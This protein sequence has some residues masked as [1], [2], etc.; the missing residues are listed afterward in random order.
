G[1]NCCFVAG[2]TLLTDILQPQEKSRI[3]GLVD[4]LINVASATGGFGGG[5]VFWAIGFTITSQIGVVVALIPLMLV[6]FLRLTQS[7]LA[8]E[9]T[10]PA[11]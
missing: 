9:G 6:F 5:I 11:H 2:S 7:Q 1:W 3:Q 8:V 10:T 4:T